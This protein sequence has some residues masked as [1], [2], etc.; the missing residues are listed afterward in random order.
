MKKYVVQKPILTSMSVDTVDD[1]T[2][3]QMLEIKNQYTDEDGDYGP[4]ETL[5][6]FE[7]FSRILYLL[8]GEGYEI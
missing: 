7:A 3:D 6:E 1:L 2:V 4:F 5:N 8:E